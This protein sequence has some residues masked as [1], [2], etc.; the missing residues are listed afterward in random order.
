MN[1]HAVMWGLIIMI[2][3]GNVTIA[4]QPKKHTG[5]ELVLTGLLSALV[6]MEIV[7]KMMGY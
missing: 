5:L 1:I 3:A 7:I 6:S 4:L 2:A